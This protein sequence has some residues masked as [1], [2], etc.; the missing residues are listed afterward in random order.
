MFR[1]VVVFVHLF[2]FVF[3]LAALVPGGTEPGEDA[4][5]FSR[6][7][8]FRFILLLPERTAES[9]EI[10]DVLEE[11]SAGSEEILI[12]GLFDGS[13]ALP[14]TAHRENQVRGVRQLPVGLNHFNFRPG[15]DVLVLP[16]GWKELP[17]TGEAGSWLTGALMNRKN[18]VLVVGSARNLLGGEAADPTGRPGIEVHGRRVL[19][20][21]ENSRRGV[22]LLRR[23]IRGW[24]W[25]LQRSPRLLCR[26]D[27]DWERLPPFPPR[28]RVVFAGMDRRWNRE[29]L[30]PA[31]RYA[32]WPLELGG[33][34][35]LQPPHWPTGS[36]WLVEPLGTW[37]ESDGPVLPPPPD[38]GPD[39]QR[40]MTL[41]AHGQ[42][43][44]LDW[45]LPAPPEQIRS[46]LPE[47]H[48]SAEQIRLALRAIALAVD[49]VRS[50]NTDDSAE[51]LLKERMLALE[52]CRTTLPRLL[53]EGNPGV[54]L[55]PTALREYP[56]PCFWPRLEDGQVVLAWFD[57]PLGE[58]RTL[59]CYVGGRPLQAKEPRD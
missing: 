10:N 25:D 30:N 5:Q 24:C 33:E 19:V 21:R 22:Q 55:L 40:E 3:P 26:L 23:I 34:L 11:L 48:A 51:L 2:C 4:A 29:G 43:V 36:V 8:A 50:G 9:A 27:V 14:E 1:S 54:P 57:L 38:N 44:E 49:S 12:G 59:R 52:K 56:Q 6:R 15:M 37:L 35:G 32:D 46:N 41:A 31:A 7:D 58:G 20:D 47:L 17:A 18:A 45:L 42:A 13:E 28:R 16:D 39:L 53:A